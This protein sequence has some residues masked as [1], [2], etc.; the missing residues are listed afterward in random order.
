M[1][2]VIPHTPYL[3]VEEY[4]KGGKQIAH[5]SI[6]SSALEMAPELPYRGVHL[7]VVKSG[8]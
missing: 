8:K 5:L 4:L 2:I 3:F 6:L 7:S 1:M